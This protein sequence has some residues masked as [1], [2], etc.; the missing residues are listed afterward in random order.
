MV[1]HILVH[2]V[3]VNRFW[4]AKAVKGHLFDHLDAADKGKSGMRM[5]AHPV[6]AQE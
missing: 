3:C 5:G 6:F 2:G 4:S 1:A